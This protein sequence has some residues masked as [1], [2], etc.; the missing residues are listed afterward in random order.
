MLRSGD[1]SARASRLTDAE[2]LHKSSSTLNGWLVGLRVRIDVVRTSID[3]DGAHLGTTRIGS[4]T[5]P[6]LDDVVFVQRTNRPSVNS[7]IGIACAPRFRFREVGRDGSDLSGGLGLVKP[8]AD[9][10]EEVPS[11]APG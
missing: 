5:E 7:Y 11:T 6:V 9:T 3:G 4:R 8:E 2:E 10:S 1:M